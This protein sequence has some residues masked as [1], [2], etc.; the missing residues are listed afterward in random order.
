MT[1]KEIIVKQQQNNIGYVKRVSADKYDYIVFDNHMSALDNNG[2]LKIFTDEELNA[3]D[4][5]IKIWESL[6]NA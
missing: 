2:F 5:E 6:D 1:L 3:D 4:W